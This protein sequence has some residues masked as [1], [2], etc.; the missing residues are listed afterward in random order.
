MK[1]YFYKNIGAF[2]L[3]IAMSGLPAIALAENNR[4]DGEGDTKTRVQ[5]QERQDTEQENQLIATSSSR[6]DDDEDDEDIEDIQ[7]DEGN[8]RF[9][10]NGTTTQARS[11]D[12]LKQTIEKRKQ[13]FEREAASTTPKDRDIAENA[14]PVRLAVHTLLASKELL[15]GIGGQVSEIAKQM[16]DS[17]A[18]TT[19][20]EVKIQS[21]SFLAR[22]FF[23]GDSSAAEVIS[24]EIAKNQQRIDDLDKL[25]A[26]AAVPADIQATLSAQIT[27]L[28]E[29][30]ARLHALAQKEQ[31]MWGLFSWRF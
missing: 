6:F 21:R 8:F 12:E 24:R 25:L 20:A 28:K 16:N 13:R 10:L 27:A 19:N 26:E 29:A 11:F 30:Q 31:K 1:K 3:A 7:D 17:A 22:L 15:G 18:T 9:S 4:V 2:V 23:G 14:N 5:V